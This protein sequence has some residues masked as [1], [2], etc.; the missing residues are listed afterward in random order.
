M[1]NIFTV[2]S[3]NVWFD[4]TL[5]SERTASLI[6]L[7]NDINPDALCFQEVRPHIYTFLITALGNYRY[8]FPKKLSKSYDCVT[9]SK[10]PIKKCL[11]YPYNNSNMGRGI[12]IA[13]IDYPYHET[14]S[15]GVSVSKVDIVI[16]NT[17]FESLFKKKHMNKI[18]IEQFEIASNILEELY[19]T[20]N[21]VILCSDTNVLDHEEEK[22][23][24]YFDDIM[25]L[26]TWKMKGSALSKYTYDS[27]NN[28]YLKGR[29]NNVKYKSRIDRILFK[30]DHL[31][32]EEFNM[33]KGNGKIIEPSDHFGVYSRFIIHK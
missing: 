21:N 8:H 10:Y 2:I 13:K 12:I 9:F 22:F 29:F 5:T 19:Q 14:T 25:W 20:Y 4:E 28:V 1:E 23:T 15:D 26:D 16:A 6:K 31:Q 17:H 33:I 32:L 27:D 18:K 24:E 3:Y 11:E 7:I 30:S